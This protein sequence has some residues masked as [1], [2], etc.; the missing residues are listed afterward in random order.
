MARFEALVS[1][2]AMGGE[3]GGFRNAR[4]GEEAVCKRRSGKGHRTLM[5]PGILRAIS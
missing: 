2:G 4:N 1:F 5:V 3:G